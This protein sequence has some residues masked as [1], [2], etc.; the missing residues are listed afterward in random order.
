[1][2]ND[3]EIRFVYVRDYEEDGVNRPLTIAYRFNDEAEQIEFN[4][5]KCSPKDQFV[6]ATGRLKAAARLTKGK[7]KPNGTIP[8]SM[9]SDGTGPKYNLIAAELHAIHTQ[10]KVCDNC[11]CD[12][13][14]NI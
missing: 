7:V 1:M 8:Y 14:F 3:S 5:A 2:K 13:K 10:P 11:V 9:V 6:K 4:T 12:T